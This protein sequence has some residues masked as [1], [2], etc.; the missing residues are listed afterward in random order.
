MTLDRALGVLAL[1]LAALLYLL[2]LLLAAAADVPRLRRVVL[3]NVW[4]GWTVVVWAYC[5]VLALSKPARSPRTS[6]SDPSL[7]DRVP[8]WLNELPLGRRPWRSLPR[9]TGA[10]PLGVEQDQ[11]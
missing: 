6:W 11:P 10:L 5:L 1:V 8:D 4:L 2:P 7:Q 3:L 9:D